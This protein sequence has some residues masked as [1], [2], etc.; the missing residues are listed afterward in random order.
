MEIKGFGLERLFGHEK[1]DAVP[2]VVAESPKKPE[3]VQ[4]GTGTEILIVD[5]SKTIHMMLTKVLLK[6]GYEVMSA[7]DGESGLE[8]LRQHRPSLVLM[9]IVMPGISGFQAT[10]EIRKDPDE[11]ISATPVLMMSGN[12]QPTEEFWSVKIGANGFLAKPFDNDKLFSHIEALLY[13]EAVALE[14]S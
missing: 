14:E 13:P 7:Y 12:E 10:R 9:D 8:M 2:E 4:P 1:E 6:F 11:I 5:D 3:R